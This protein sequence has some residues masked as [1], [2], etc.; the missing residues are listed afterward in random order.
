MQLPDQVER[1]EASIE[2]KGKGLPFCL[3]VLLTLVEDVHKFQH[4]I[5]HGRGPGVLGVK[6]GL[7]SEN[8]V[9]EAI[10]GSK[11]FEAVGVRLP[12]YVASVHRVQIIW[13]SS[14]IDGHI[15]RY[16][17]NGEVMSQ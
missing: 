13:Q 10:A 3:V 2:V 12:R 9:H 5:L 1:A 14:F 16:L 11:E 15:S 7:V 8:M 6:V 4:E 17:A